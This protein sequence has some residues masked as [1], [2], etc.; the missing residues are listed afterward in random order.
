[1]SEPVKVDGW[2]VYEDGAAEGEMS[3]AII[4]DGELSVDRDTGSPEGGI[5]HTWIP[6]SVAAA[7]LRATGWH[8][9][10]PGHCRDCGE[11]KGDGVCWG[12]YDSRPERE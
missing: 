6:V 3:D 12:C 11:P 9:V 1:M 7:M 4:I 10:P 5:Q 2:D 8:V